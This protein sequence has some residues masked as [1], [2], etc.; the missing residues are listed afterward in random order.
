M[1]ARSENHTKTINLAT[2]RGQNTEMLNAVAGPCKVPI[3]PLG[4]VVSV[5]AIGYKVCWFILGRGD[6]FS[7]Q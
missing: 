3:C 2:I 7:G 5:L 6:G 4:G 1:P